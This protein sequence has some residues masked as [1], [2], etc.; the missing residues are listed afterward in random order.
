MPVACVYGWDPTLMLAAGT[1]LTILDEWRW[2]GAMRN[3]PVPLVPCETIDL[4]VPA[5]AEIVIEGTI[6]PD[7]ATYQ[8]EGPLKEV[9][10]RYCH[11]SPMHF[12]ML[13]FFAR[14]L[15]KS[16]QRAYL[17]G[18]KIFEFPGGN[19]DNPSPESQ[20]I[21][22][23]GMGPYL[24]IRFF[25]QCDGSTHDMGISAM[26]SA[27]DIGRTDQPDNLLIEA[28]FIGSKAFTHVAV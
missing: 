11:Q 1:P 6:S 12:N 25:C 16:I 7:P 20:Q 19:F 13:Q 4:E 22:Q 14:C 5:T 23:S 15:H 21:R 9:S 8:P 27:P 18:E 2:I 10:G 26:K 3:E 28:D 24:D 17:I